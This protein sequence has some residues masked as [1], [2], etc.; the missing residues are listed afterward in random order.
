MERSVNG[1][2]DG[3]PGARW[4]A[5]IKLSPVQE[6]RARAIM[7]RTRPRCLACGCTEAG[8]EEASLA[9]FLV[10]RLGTHVWS[11]RVRCANPSCPAPEST[12]DIR[13]ADL[14]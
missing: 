7:H 9:G 3:G 1:R 4:P 10:H 6:Q 14:I 12:L 5:P 11:V 13:A 8:V 2:R